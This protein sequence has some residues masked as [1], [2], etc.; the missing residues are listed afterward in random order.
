MLRHLHTG[1]PNCSDDLSVFE[2]FFLLRV[3]FSIDVDP[4]FLSFEHDVT[5]SCKVGDEDTL[6][7][8]HRFGFDMFVG[9]AVFLNCVYMHPALVGKRTFPDI[10]LMVPVCFVGQFI[11]ER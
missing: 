2:L 3:L 9:F 1:T 8:A 10:R 7:I 11:Y 4:I 6:H 5:F